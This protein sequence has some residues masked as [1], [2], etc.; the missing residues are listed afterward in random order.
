MV[1]LVDLQR[2]TSYR[3][4][5]QHL[6]QVFEVMVEGPA[7]KPSQLMGRNDG[8]KIVV[9]PNN[10]AIPGG[11]VSVRVNEVTPNTLIGEVA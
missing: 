7:K 3:R 2:Q 1:Q 4:N 5:Q 9:F 6:G 10:G 8:N 11:I